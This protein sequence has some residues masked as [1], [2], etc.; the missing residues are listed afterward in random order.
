MD[1]KNRATQK[2]P[3]QEGGP[4]NLFAYTSTDVLST[5][6]VRYFAIT[7]KAQVGP[8]AAGERFSMAILHASGLLAL[9]RDD[10][11][12]EGTT[13]R[14]DLTIRDQLARPFGT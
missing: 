8:F 3:N 14:V 13:F 1:N 9:H 12:T 4:V 7:L 5:D 11:D 10:T 6:I 2:T